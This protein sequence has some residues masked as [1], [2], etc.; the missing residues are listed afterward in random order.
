[1]GELR[2][3]LRVAIVRCARHLARGCASAGA[4]AELENA[5]RGAIH[6]AAG[7]PARKVGSNA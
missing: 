3:I 2:A 6:D 7:I 5:R 1:M 4:E